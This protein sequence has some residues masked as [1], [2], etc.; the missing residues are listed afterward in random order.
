MGYYGLSPKYICCQYMPSKQAKIYW[1]MPKIIKKKVFCSGCSYKCF[2]LVFRW[3]E[4]FYVAHGL[5]TLLKLDRVP[6]WSQTNPLLN[7]PLRT[8]GWST[9]TE[10]YDFTG[11]AYLPS[12]QNR[13]NF[14]TNDAILNSFGIYIVLKLSNIVYVMTGCC[15]FYRLGC[16]AP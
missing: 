9:K 5:M 15:I 12:R 8:V 6:C 4:E 2:L 1:I 7:P 3:K 13:R 10:I 16:G 14:R 11:T